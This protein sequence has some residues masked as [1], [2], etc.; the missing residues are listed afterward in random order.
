MIRRLPYLM[1]SFM[2]WV[3]I[4]VV[5]WF[6]S[7]IFSERVSTLAAVLGSRAAVCSSSNRSFGF[8]SVAISSVTA[9]RWP[10]ERSPTLLVMRFSNPKSSVL[11]SS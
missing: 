5:R 10:P 2:L 6:S 9:W 8:F 1:A 11:S 3:I 7:T 4:R